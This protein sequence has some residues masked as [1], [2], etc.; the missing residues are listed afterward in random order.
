MTLIYCN[1]MKLAINLADVSGSWSKAGARSQGQVVKSNFLQEK[2]NFQIVKFLFSKD[3]VTTI[4][5]IASCIQTK[6]GFHG[7]VPFFI[8]CCIPVHILFI[9]HRCAPA[10]EWECIRANRVA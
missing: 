2:S 1:N 7:I 6:R 9:G 10:K 8:R 3:T 4:L 5:F